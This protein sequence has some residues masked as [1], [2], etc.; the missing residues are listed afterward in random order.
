MIGGLGLK[1]GFGPCKMPPQCWQCPYDAPFNIYGPGEYAGPAR[2]QRMPEYRL[3]TGDEIQLLFM[4]VPLKTDG[5]YLLNAGDEVMIEAGNE[6]EINR[7][8]LDKGLTIQPDGT[9]N[10]WR[11]GQVQAAGQSVSQL[12]AL[13][14]ER[15]K[16]FYQEPE[17]QVTPVNTGT[18]VIRIREALS[19]ANGFNPQEVLQRITPSGEIRL[20]RIGSVRRSGRL[21]RN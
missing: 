3:R 18:D 5:D 4:V 8:T 2:V 21:S 9:L 20:P 7:G 12:E 15:Y 11:V 17:I 19:G 16:K 10:L 1:N 13:L 14:E 6:P